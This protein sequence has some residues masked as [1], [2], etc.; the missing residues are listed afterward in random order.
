MGAR[1]QLTMSKVSVV[2]N[3]CHAFDDCNPKGIHSMQL[4]RAVEHD[5]ELRIDDRDMGSP[6]ETLRFTVRVPTEEE[7]NR[8]MQAPVAPI[9]VDAESVNKSK[10][11]QR[12]R[13]VKDGDALWEQGWQNIHQGIDSGP[14]SP[15]E[16]ARKK[17]RADAALMREREEHEEGE[18]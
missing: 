12:I 17:A 4:K 10:I 9:G 16:K 7:W 11:S 2:Q 14:G 15:Q 18:K 6:R 8:T 13:K 3:R 1:S 5:F